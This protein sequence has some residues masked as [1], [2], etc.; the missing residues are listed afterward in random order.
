MAKSQQDQSFDDAR[1]SNDFND[2]EHDSNTTDTK[3]TKD[4]IG[5]EVEY[6]SPAQGALVMVA[7]LL[8]LFL[9]ILVSQRAPTIH[10]IAI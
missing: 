5:E 9:S 7:L 3:T 4:T 1:T 2:K 6:P 10:P 8:A